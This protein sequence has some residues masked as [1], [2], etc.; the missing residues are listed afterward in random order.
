MSRSGPSNDAELSNL[1]KMIRLNPA[2]DIIEA[3]NK[4]LDHISFPAKSLHQHHIDIMELIS[5]LYRFSTNN[6]IAIEEL[7]GDMRTLYGSLLDLG[8]NALRKW[9]TDISLSFREKLIIARSR[10]TKS[11]VYKAEE[12]VRNNYSDEGLS[13]DTIC[14][15]LG[16]S[17]SYFS[18]IFKKET[19]NSFICYLTDYRMEQASR[20]LIETN[21][22]SYIIANNVGYSD[23]NYFS[24]VFKRRY[25]VSP[26]KYRTEHAESGK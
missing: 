19:G 25:G 11:F 2:E 21:E 23:P 9:L 6:D 8:P 14:E 24:Y 7:S 5:A 3:V 12:Y 20:L 15:V 13:L 26:S 18:T 17:N 16:V 22:K 1:F 10:S 4:Y